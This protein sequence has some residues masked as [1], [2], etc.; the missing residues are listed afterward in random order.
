M[1]RVS[2]REFIGEIPDGMLVC[3]RCDNRRCLNPAHLFLGTHADNSMDAARKGRLFR[4]EPRRGEAHHAA[5][6]TERDVA[7]VLERTDLT[8]QE[9]ASALG[10]SQS[11][12]SRVRRGEGWRCVP[13]CAEDSPEATDAD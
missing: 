6:L 5:K 4:S 11:T 13:R 8:Q 12:I 9:A 3:H 10:V 7:W 2:Y 1:H